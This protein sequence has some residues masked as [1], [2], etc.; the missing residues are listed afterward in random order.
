MLKFEVP[1]L[2]GETLSLYST[3]AIIG[4][5]TC[6]SR[7]SLL[8]EGVGK[9]DLSC[10]IAEFEQLMDKFCEEDMQEM[11][12]RFGFSFSRKEKPKGE[13]VRLHPKD[14]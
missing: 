11:E 5:L 4:V 9:F 7:C 2:D 6:G 12:D 1:L 10:S 3:D 14:E 8:I 13:L